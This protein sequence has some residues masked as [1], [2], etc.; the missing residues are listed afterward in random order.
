MLALDS[1]VWAQLSTAYG[2]AEEVPQ[3]LALLA[4]QYNQQQAEELY[5]ELLHQDTLYTA[6][7]AA[8][9]HLLSIAAR[10]E[11]TSAMMSIYIDCG[12]I[13][14]EYEIDQNPRIDS[15]LDPS[16][17]HDIEQAYCQAVQNM[18]LLHD[19]ILPI[20]SGPTIDPLE[21]QYVLAAWMAY[22]GYQNVARL[23][24]HYPE[25][26][27]YPAICPHCSKEWYI[28]PPDEHNQQTSWIVYPDDPVTSDNKYGRMIQP[29]RDSNTADPECTD[30]ERID[31][32]LAELS[33]RAGE[34]GLMD[35]QQRIP[36]LAGEVICPHCQE[37][38]NV[39]KGILEHCI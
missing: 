11:D 1:P 13:A 20:L 32:E 30:L 37:K 28:W 26:E 7:L 15:H 34:F 17:Y 4:Q 12:M 6:T 19:R 9:P 33:V 22:H 3:Q 36:Y 27:E 25:G 31:P 39:W 38:G 18:N 5:E 21:K 2:S 23:L 16:L 14:A 10:F 8:V 29:N 24:F 35:L